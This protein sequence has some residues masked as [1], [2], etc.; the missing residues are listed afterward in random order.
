MG[1]ILTA[2]RTGSSLPGEADVRY[3]RHGASSS[4]QARRRILRIPPSFF[5]ISVGL[6]GLAH[7]WGAAS[8]LLG[9][10][11]QIADA[12]S[13]LAAAVWLAFVVAYLAQGWRQVRAD[14]TNVMLSPFVPVSV[15]TRCSW[16]RRSSQLRSRPRVC[17]LASCG[18]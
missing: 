6:A 1:Q 7:A 2:N 11:L 12:L 16:R 5:S 3:A 4:A 15:I 17:S 14:V 9:I 18:C 8:G 13:A 10:P